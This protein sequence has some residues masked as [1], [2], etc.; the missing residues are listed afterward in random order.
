M[1]QNAHLHETTKDTLLE[2]YHEVANRQKI[3]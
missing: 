2:I 3:V 1:S